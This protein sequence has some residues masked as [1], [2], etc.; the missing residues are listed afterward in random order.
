ML[1]IVLEYVSCLN[2]KLKTVLLLWWLI[3]IR[4][5]IQ[6]EDVYKCRL[7]SFSVDCLHFLQYMDGENK[8]TGGIVKLKE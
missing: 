6:V 8:Y 7:P 1:E 5:L 4:Q 2:M 3:A